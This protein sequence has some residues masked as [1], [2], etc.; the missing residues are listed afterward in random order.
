MER[1]PI[2]AILAAGATLRTVDGRHVRVRP[3]RPTDAEDI[4]AFV[5]GLSDASRYMRFFAPVRELT[6]AM[7]ARLTASDGGSGRVFV[8]LSDHAESHRIVAMA[9][10][11]VDRSAAARI[12]TACDLA[13][14]VADDW[15]RRGLGST[16]LE[17][18][19]AS[20]REE[21]FA[22]AMGDVLRGNDAMLRLARA[23]G[24]A[25]RHS[26]IDGTMF[27]VVRNLVDQLPARSGSP[28]N[29]SLQNPPPWN[30]SPI[31]SGAS[32]AWA[33]SATSR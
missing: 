4:Q 26:P 17:M 3:A 6:P 11:A 25:V 14:V 31:G 15:Q 2:A 24:F 7:L 28:A 33:A 12:G 23:S 10:Y 29:S 1:A 8:V 20:A 22:C 16:L 19:L 32:F 18:L 30:R 21:G 5:R 13:L 27:R 9:E